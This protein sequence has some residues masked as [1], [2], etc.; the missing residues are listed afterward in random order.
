MAERLKFYLLD[1]DPTALGMAKALLEKA[2]HE[3]VTNSS[4]VEAL[5]EIP[6]AKPDCVLLDIMMPELDGLEMC[7][8]LR[9]SP[10]V[11]G[12]KIIILSGKAYEFDRKRAFEMGANGYILKPI[13]PASFLPDILSVLSDK[14][15]LKYWGVRGTL[16]VSGQRSLHYGGNTNCVALTM[17]NDKL[18]IFDCGSG[19]KELAN[20]LMAKRKRRID[21]KIFISHP[22]W[23]H[24]NAFPFFTPLYMQG[25]QFEILGASHGK[26]SM[27]DLISSQME[28]VYFPI[29]IR[30]F[31]A[32]VTF[33]D[34]KEGTYEIDGV[35]VKTMLLS[36]P[37]YCLGYHVEYGGRAVCYVTDNEMF[38]PDSDFFSED[39]VNRLANFVRECDI[40]ITDTTYT[41]RE[42]ESKVGWGHSCVSQVVDLA[43]RA[44]VKELHISHHDPDQNDDAIDAKFAVCRQLIQERGSAVVCKAPKEAEEVSL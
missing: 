31:G 30:E 17:P 16:P 32:Y 19:I 14:M 4:S 38:L 35:T 3:V 34:L 5:A 37:G 27:R 21:G 10:D 20:E 41:D 12:L 40:L 24:I 44:E 29:T 39:Y 23:D 22:Y 1:D 11:P 9:A 33:R 36:H 25:N 2:G 26:L 7:R 43:V 15:T 6:Q 42:Y 8:Q 28:G 13:R 18:F